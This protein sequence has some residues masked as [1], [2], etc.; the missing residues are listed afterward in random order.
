MGRG[1]KSDNEAAKDHV[2]QPLSSLK[3]PKSFGPPPKSLTYTGG[4]TSTPTAT[5]QDGVP[6]ERTTVSEPELEPAP[7]AGPYRVD[8]TGLSTKNLPKPPVRRLNN[9]TPSSPARVSASSKP[10]TKPKP[11]LPP[12]LPPR[13]AATIPSSPPPSYGIATQSDPPKEQYLNQGALNRLTKAGVSVPGLG[14][15][16]TGPTTSS[17]QSSS[18]GIKD[19]QPRFSQPTSASPSTPNRTTL[20]QKQEALKT[21]PSLYRDS[22]S[23]T[24]DNAR[25]A[26]TTISGFRERHGEEVSKGWQ[27]ANSLNQKIGISDKIGG[28][29]TPEQKSVSSPL[30]R[31]AIPGKKPVPP[32]PPKRTDV[33]SKAGPPP[34]PLGTKPK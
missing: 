1:K 13:Q 21:A 32:P 16:T 6:Q 27:G 24:V 34:V 3:D 8:T 18:S 14:I 25:S 2:S 10:D 15:G 11:T 19:L 31:P 7:P 9:E 5:V 12:R 28:I 4:D 29:T 33:Q 17:S 26:A 20:A 22:S 30:A 23:V